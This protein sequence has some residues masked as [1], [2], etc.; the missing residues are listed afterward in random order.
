M[1][2]VVTVHDLAVLRHPETFNLWTRRYSRVVRTSGGAGGERG[3]SPSPSSRSA[4]SSSCS[5]RRR[6]K[7]TRHPQRRGRG[8]LARRPAAE[9]DYVLAVGHARAAEEPRARRRRRSP[10]RR[11]AAGRRRARLGR[12][13]R[14]RAGSARVSDDELARLYRGAKCV[15]YA[16]LYEGFGLPIA[17]AMACGT[18]VVTSAAAR[19]RRRPAAPPCSSI[20]MTRPRSPLGSRK[21]SSGAT[22]C[23]ARP[24]AR[25]RLLLGRGRARDRGRLPRGGRV[26]LVV[27]DADV[28]GR[29]R[30]GDETYVLNLL[31][32][33]PAAAPATLRFAALTRR[34]DLVPEGIEAVH[35]PGALPGAAHGVV[36][37][38]RAATAS[39]RRSRTSST[40]CRCAARARPWSRSTTSRSSAILRVMPLHD[41][42][43]FKTVVPRSAQARRARPRRVGADE[44][45]HRRAVRHRAGEDHGHAARRRS[46]VLA[47]RRQARRV[48]VVRRSRSRSART[49]WRPPPRPPRSACRSSSP[50]PCATRSSRESSSGA[51]PS[52][53]AM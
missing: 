5:A 25:P 42:L 50:G 8:L 1:P 9:G 39:G 53:A 46:R 44:G 29:R 28:L 23:A 22:S 31:R 51:A 34:P 7:V 36:G 11:R 4:S 49:R 48:P 33:L 52:F 16:S 19:R 17:E 3:S 15:V 32:H 43:V 2:L 26:S 35:V 21:R 27:V 14:P 13:A 30:T 47:G 37:A 12:R 40:R 38:A 45:R 41:R 10:G 24:R 20:R 18:P 6:S